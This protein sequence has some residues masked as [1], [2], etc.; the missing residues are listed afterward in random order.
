LNIKVTKL[1]VTSLKWFPLVGTS[2]SS[3]RAY[4]TLQ[5]LPSLLVAFGLQE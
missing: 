1:I 3:N 2:R 4:S 5:T